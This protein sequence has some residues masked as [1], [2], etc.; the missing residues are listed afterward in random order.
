MVRFLNKMKA[1]LMYNTGIPGNKKCTV[2]YSAVEIY[3][4]D[5]IY[6]Q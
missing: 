2:L 6:E 5:N 1:T 4:L 3:S